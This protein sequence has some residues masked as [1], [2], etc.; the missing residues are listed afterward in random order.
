MK[1]FHSLST[2]SIQSSIAE[3]QF[4]KEHYKKQVEYLVSSHLNFFILFA[5]DLWCIEPVPFIEFLYRVSVQRQ[6]VMFTSPGYRI[7]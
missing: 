2:L 1:P 3:I 7:R 5:S 4:F 6:F